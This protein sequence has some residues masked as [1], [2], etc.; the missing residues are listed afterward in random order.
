MATGALKVPRT[1]LAKPATL[2]VP[3]A[4]PS[5]SDTSN[6]KSTILRMMLLLVSTMPTSK[7]APRMQ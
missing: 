4:P 1:P 6:V 5:K 3:S 2:D 7:F